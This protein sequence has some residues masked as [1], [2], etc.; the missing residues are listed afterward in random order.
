[1]YEGGGILGVVIHLAT[2]MDENANG[3]PQSGSTGSTGQAEMKQDVM[4]FIGKVEAWLDE[5]MVTKAPFQIPMGGK[6]FLAKIAPYLIIIGV[7]FFVLSLPALLGLG[8]MFGGLGMMTGSASWGFAALVSLA[9]SVIT[10]GLEAWAVPG[11][12]KRTH[13]SWRILFYA[14]LISLIGGILSYNPIGAVI[15]AIIGWYIL[16]QVKVLYKN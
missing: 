15:G 10:V 12:F 9:T 7:V 1:M 5:Y 8:A 2:Y 13:A 16:F 11:L 3:A 4:G 6:E 14:S